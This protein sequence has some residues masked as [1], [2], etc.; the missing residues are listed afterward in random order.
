MLRTPAVAAPPPGAGKK[1][2]NSSQSNHSISETRAAQA[3]LKPL[4]PK[5]EIL[6]F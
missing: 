4:I 5:L 2:M 1:H 3:A 6:V